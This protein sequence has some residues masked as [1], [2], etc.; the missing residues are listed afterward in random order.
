M[1]LPNDPD[2]VDILAKNGVDIS[3][4]EGDQQGNAVS[5][6]ANLLFPLIAFGGLFFLFSRA[7]GGQGGMGGGNPFGG[8]PMDFGKSKS[9]FQE[10]PETGVKFADVA[11]VDG[12]KM[13]LQ[14]VV[15]FL[16]NPDKYTALGAKIPKGCLLVGPP[17]TGKTLLAKAVAGEAGV[18]FFSCAA[19]EFVELFV[20]VGASRVRDLFEKA[21]A[22]AP[23]IVFIDEIDAVGR[24]RG[25]G[26]GGGNDEREQ[27]INQL[28]TEMDGFEGNTGVIVLAATNR[29]DVLDSALLRPGRFDRQVT[30]DRPDLQGRVRILGVHSKGKAISKDIDFEKIARRTPGFTGAD[31]Q[32]LMNEAAIIAARR[33]LTEITKEEVAD[34]LERI[35]AGAEKKGAVISEPKRKLVAYHEAGHALVGALMPEYDPV[36]KISIVPRGGAGGLTFFAPSEERLESGLYSRTYLENQMCVALGGRIAEELIFGEQNVTTGASSDFQQVTRTARMM[37]TQM[38]F[39]KKLGQLALVSGGGPSFLGQ[40]VGRSADYSQATADAIEGEVKDLVMTAYRR[41]KDLVQSNMNVLHKVAEVLL[42]KE[43]ID[44]DEF[45]RIFMELRSQLYLKVDSPQTRVPFT[46][47]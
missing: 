35:V 12:A 15:D 41:A 13:E 23:C 33:S 28:L 8:G 44:G 2:L 17:G 4:S 45:E 32:N 18:P 27:T 36:T 25:A 11:G 16:K 30:V 39:S 20:G 7:Q 3:V 19:S 29:P 6:V 42:E 26:M 40:D 43:S 31:L 21:K 24:Q 14:E 47:A 9:K 37:V 1:V 10:V 5:L 38:G 34:A 46:A 22:K